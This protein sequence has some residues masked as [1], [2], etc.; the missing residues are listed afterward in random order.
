MTKYRMDLY[1]RLSPLTI[2]L[3]FEDLKAASL[4]AS[5]SMIESREI[6][7]KAYA[8]EGLSLFGLILSDIDIYLLSFQE[9]WNDEV[10]KKI[11]MKLGFWFNRLS[12]N[13]MKQYFE[14]AKMNVLD[15]YKITVI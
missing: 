1:N 14:K 8:E 7:I 4:P 12:N 13:E 11:A 10:S 5:D 3:S 6:I 9:S 2:K 15:R